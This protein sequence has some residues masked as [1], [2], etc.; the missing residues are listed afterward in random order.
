MLNVLGTI[1][2]ESMFVSRDVVDGD[3]D[4]SEITSYSHPHRPHQR[5]A[6]YPQY[7]NSA[8]RMRSFSSWRN[9]FPP[10]EQMVDSGFFYLGLYLVSLCVLLTG[11]LD[12]RP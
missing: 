4:V 1:P 10:V 2:T 11:R 9:P 12:G 8:E 6:R 5:Q 3:N 7:E